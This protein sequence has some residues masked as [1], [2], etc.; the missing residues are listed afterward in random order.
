MKRNLLVI[1]L[2]IFCSNWALGQ[3]STPFAL[4]LPPINKQDLNLKYIGKDSSSVISRINRDA[5]V[6]YIAQHQID[7][8]VVRENTT[9]PRP[10]MPIAPYDTSIQYHILS[11]QPD[12]STLY[13]LRT[14]K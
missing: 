3:S 10:V 14:K 13:H 9:N 4:S 11:I 6:R 5:E 7:K 1:S 12:S 2:M 8:C